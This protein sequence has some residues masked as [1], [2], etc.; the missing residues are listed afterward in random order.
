MRTDVLTFTGI[1]HLTEPVALNRLFVNARLRHKKDVAAT[2]TA[3]QNGSVSAD[4]VK[5]SVWVLAG[6][7]KGFLMSF[8]SSYTSRAALPPMLQWPPPLLLQWNNPPAVD[9]WV[10]LG[11]LFSKGPSGSPVSVPGETWIE[12]SLTTAVSGEVDDMSHIYSS[13][14]AITSLPLLSTIMS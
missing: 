2:A 7:I 9:F 11:I 1:F 4:S 13:V 14:S 5:S 10:A 6:S 8:T 12:R 3:N